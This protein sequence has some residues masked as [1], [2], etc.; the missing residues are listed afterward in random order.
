MLLKQLS[1]G[2][3]SS[4]YTT[5]FHRRILGVPRTRGLHKGDKKSWPLA[6]EREQRGPRVRSTRGY[7]L[8]FHGADEEM[9]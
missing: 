6:T 4:A 7:L 3:Q 2:L 5:Q 8:H 1:L 9:L